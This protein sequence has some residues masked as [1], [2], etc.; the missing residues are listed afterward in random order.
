MAKAKPARKPPLLAIGIVL[1]LVAWLVPVFQG[2]QLF[3]SMGELGKSLG[4]HPE[5]TIAPLSGPEWLPG[6]AACHFSWS[7]LTE[8]QGQG[9][10][11]WKRIVVGSTCLTNVIMLFALVARACGA[12]PRVLGVLLLACA[13]LDASW[14]YL[15]GADLIR[16]LRAGYYLWTASFVLAG[17]GMLLPGG[18][19]PRK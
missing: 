18:S 3:G 14:L 16:T 8:Q 1:Y 13:V 19:R 4:A 15:G 12:R 7:L 10:N 5:S 2:Q 6:W 11:D 9:G 17:I